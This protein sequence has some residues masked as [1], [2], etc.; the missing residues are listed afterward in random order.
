MKDDCRSNLIPP[1]R[2]VLGLVKFKEVPLQKVRRSE[3]QQAAADLTTF[4][5]APSEL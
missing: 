1:L 4:D 3:G 2:N 5:P